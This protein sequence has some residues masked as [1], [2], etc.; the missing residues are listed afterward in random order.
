M[1]GKLKE[2]R[3]SAYIYASFIIV[4]VV[5]VLSA[6]IE[7]FRIYVTVG[8]VEKA[9][10]KAMLST[11]I[12]NYDEIFTTVREGTQ[13][14]GNFDG[15]NETLIDSV[16][17]PIWVNINDYGDILG[18]LADV[19]NIEYDGESAIKLIDNKG[20]IMYRV[21]NLNINIIET[22]GYSGEQRYELKGSFDISLP[23]YFCGKQLLTCDLT[24]PAKAAWKSKL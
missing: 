16:E 15:G 22:A 14:G 7:Y 9:Y 6:F 19:L 23:V 1:I 21:S 10:E 20:M 18:E 13:M 24:V 3:A 17:K 11:A 12:E 8:I 4:A 5:I 2:N